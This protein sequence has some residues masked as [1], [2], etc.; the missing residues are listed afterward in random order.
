MT[1]PTRLT[2]KLREAP[3]DVLIGRGLLG[4]LGGAVT[5]V[6]RG[7][8]VMVVTQ[9]G[10]PV[11]IVDAFVSSL[12][13]AG[14]APLLHHLPE[15]EEAKTAGAVA[16]LHD[17]FVEAGFD[18]QS[19]VCAVGG[20][21]VGDAAGY[22]AGTYMRGIDVVQ[23]P[24]TLTAMVDASIG[25]KTAVNHPRA[26]NV[27]G[28]F[29]QPRLVL[30]DTSLLDRLPERDYR[31]GLA[32]V[33]RSACIGDRRL[34]E[35]LEEG[36]DR[37]LAREPATVDEMVVRA[38]AVKIALVSRDPRELRGRRIL[39]N[40]GHTLGH[41]VEAAGGFERYRHGEAVAIGM[42]AAA[43]LAARLGVCSRRCCDR[44]IILLHRM[45]LPTTIS[46]IPLEMIVN[47]LKLD[48]K[49]KQGVSRF[50]LTPRIGSAKVI[51]GLPAPEAVAALREEI[52]ETPVRRR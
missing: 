34:F 45:G 24:T 21:S 31:A 20:G 15:G 29:H 46:D 50:I 37:V 51:E 30:A 25:G 1:N 10:I 40:Y 12:G 8:R 18:R 42:A 11:P 41:A 6:M 9:A 19:T 28:V 17:A 7:S 23:V 22:A 32:E 33:V 44:Q 43:R 4:R 48:K 5:G 35:L 13:K 3:Y 49:F 16:A 47:S 52:I 26:K 39:L 14:R 2:L 27:I 38:A 36:L